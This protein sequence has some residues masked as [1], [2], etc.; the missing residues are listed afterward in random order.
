MAER[1]KS[2]YDEKAKERTMR[3]LK[4]YYSSL[5]LNLRK[6]VKEKYKAFAASKGMSVTEL[7]TRWLDDEIERSGFE[8]TP[9]PDA[10]D[11]STE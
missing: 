7:I 2:Q 9:E 6:R 5:C 1:K 3:H 11:E 10:E 8:Y 4:K